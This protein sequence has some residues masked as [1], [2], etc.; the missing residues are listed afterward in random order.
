MTRYTVV[1]VQSVED[2]L[3]EIWLSA[4][5]RNAITSATDTIDRELGMDAES[6]GEDAAEG[7]RSLIVSPLRVIFT[8]KTDDRIVEVVRVALL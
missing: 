6:K 3:V 2:E 4:D 1:W 5:D 8:V 7:L